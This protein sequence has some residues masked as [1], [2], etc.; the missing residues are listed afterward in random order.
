MTVDRRLLTRAK[1]VVVKVGSSSLTGDNGFLD[2]VA[3]GA[4]VDAVAGLRTRGAQVVLVTSGSIAAALKLLGMT[5]RPRDLSYAQAVASVGQGMLIGAYAKQF[6]RHDL[7]VGQ[8]LL[9]NDDLARHTHFQNAERALNRLLDMGVIPIVNENDTVAT[10]EIRFGDNDRLAALVSLAVAA[11]AL[12]LLTDVDGL[13]TAAPDTP[14]AERIATVTSPDQIADVDISHRGHKLGTGGMVT[15]LEAAGIAT[16]AGIPVVLGRAKAADQILAGE[17]VGT[18]FL[19]TG[20]RSKAL[21]QWLAHAAKTHGQLVLD[22]GAVKAVRGGKASLLAAGVSA[23]RG[24]FA[25]GVPIELVG[26]D[27]TLVARGLAA[28]AAHE[29]P[30]LLGQSTEHIRA[31]FGEEM[32]RPLV[33]IDDLVVVHAS[34]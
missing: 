14:G 3:L 12:V 18:L 16:R 24:E 21:E 13:Y 19:P 11:D 25:A 26:P 32:A 20:R 33:H 7:N 28:Y 27:G 23:V 17:D 8:V 29:I 34:G 9:T 10:E 15:K 6:R 1:R 2:E 31:E 4:L 30:A 5:E 22:D